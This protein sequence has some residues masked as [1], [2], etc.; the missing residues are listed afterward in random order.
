MR[1]EETKRL[2]NRIR[3]SLGQQFR[4]GSLFWSEDPITGR[5]V[6]VNPNRAFRHSEFPGKTVG[7][8][9]RKE[10]FYCSGQT[11][12]TLF[13]VDP[14]GMV[15]IP[16]EEKSIRKA[17]RFLDKK[18]RNNPKIF[19]EMV[20]KIARHT[21]PKEDWLARTFLNLIPSMT[22]Y[23]ELSLV[24][25]VNPAFHSKHMHELPVETI[26]A[27]I[28][29]WQTIEE[30][31][32][33][34]RME[35]IPFINGGKRPESGQSVYHF[36]TQTY[37]A[38]TPPLYKQIARRRKTQGCGVCQIL[39]KRSLVIYA[40]REFKVAVH[41]APARNH[42][43]LIAPRRCSPFLR[44][45][46]KEAFADALRR[47]LVA[48]TLLTGVVPGY[49][50]AIRCGKPVGHLHVELVPKTETN[51]PAGFEEATGI[52]LITEPPLKVSQLLKRLLS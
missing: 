21:L 14:E 23:P 51:I 27:V 48:T 38:P 16:E 30:L 45:V 36:H 47:S 29:S 9:T 44:E 18:D 5:T 2:E 17:S 8:T 1:S 11:T 52:V 41:P 3:A 12:A 37:I 10:C 6:A 40:N 22:D 28:T 43:L 46:S 31:A 35:T 33:A 24:T 49:N 25:A 39:S 20:K 19:Y 34:N 32:R 4:P 7:L 42:S 13:Y 50:M 15:I 26:E